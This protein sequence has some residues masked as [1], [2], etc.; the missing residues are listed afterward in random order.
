MSRVLVTGR[1][2]D[3]EAS[4]ID[5]EFGHH[6]GIK[7]RLDNVAVTPNHAGKRY[8]PL[9]TAYHA[10]VVSAIKAN[11]KDGKRDMTFEAEIQAIGGRDGKQP[12]SKIA[13][14]RVVS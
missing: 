11:E 14:L 3:I 13:L 4:E 2:V 5:N 1:V 9:C 10:D 12:W 7:G 6:V 8:V